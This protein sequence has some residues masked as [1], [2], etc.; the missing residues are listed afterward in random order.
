M[1]SVAPFGYKFEGLEKGKKIVINPDDAKIVRLIFDLYI[2]HQSTMKVAEELLTLGIKTRFGNEFTPKKVSK[3]LAEDTYTGV[4][5]YG[6]YEK[7]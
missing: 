4:W 1:Q 2:Q 6:K 5:H 7:R 3:V